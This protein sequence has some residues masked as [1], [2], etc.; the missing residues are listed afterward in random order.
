MERPELFLAVHEAGLKYAKAQVERLEQILFKFGI[1]KAGRLLDAACGIG[2]HSAHFASRG[3]RVVGLELVPQYVE[4][5]RKLAHE[6]EVESRVDFRTGDLREVA[7][8]LEGEAPFDAII[9]ILT[10]IGYWEDET[11]LSIL[12][13]LHDLARP[14]GVLVLDTINRDYV[15]RHFE[16]TSVEE[17]GDVAYTERRALELE[18]SRI[19]SQWTFYRKRGEDLEHALSVDVSQRIYSPHELHEL[20]R[21]SGWRKVEVFSGWDLKPLSTDI[22]RLLAVGRKED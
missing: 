21:R 13:Q 18:T 10:S 5:A 16:P 14:E 11:D 2:R 7:S 1:P 12:R 22:Y 6:M 15:L 9:N 19:R 3:W 8:L 4:R 17:F 20:L